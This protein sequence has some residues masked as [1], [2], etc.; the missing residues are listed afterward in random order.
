[1]KIIYKS[2]SIAI[3]TILISACDNSTS[4]NNPD[5]N[6]TQSLNIIEDKNETIDVVENNNEII[7]VIKDK[8]ETSDVIENHNEIINITEDKNETTNSLTNTGINY[9]DAENYKIDKWSILSNYSNSATIENTYDDVLNSRV[10]YLDAKIKNNDMKS[11][12]TFRFNG[13]A[14][15]N[16]KFIQWNMK[17]NQIFTISINVETSKG[18]RSIEYI[19]KDTGAGKYDD[20]IVHGIGSDKTN[21]KWHTIT[22]DLERDVKRYEADNNFI[23]I[24]YMTIQGGGYIDNIKSY[25]VE[26]DLEVNKPVIVSKPGIVLTFDDSLIDNWNEM[27]N[28]FKEKGAVAT[29]FCNRWASHQDWELPADQIALLKSFRD[30]GHEIA[31]HTSDHI[32][33]R[34]H[35]YDN[36]PNK[37]QAYL[38][39]QILEGVADMRNKGFEPTSFSYPYVSG[40]PAHNALIRQELPHIRAF[41]AHVTLTDEPGNQS[42]DDIRTHLE[43][44][45]A[46]K[47]IGVFLS[48]WILYD[49]ANYK[50]KK[51]YKYRISK[52]KLIQIMDMVNE[53]GLEFYTL[54]EAHNIYMNQ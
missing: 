28:T 17:F 24:N 44:L 12:D 40:Q 25:K 39:D 53:L 21:N 35:K 5:T 50:T 26:G 14:N 54:E 9:E 2:L 10:I 8:N 52:E 27:Q 38:E 16:N 3:F 32:S 49:D 51:R 30:N 15:E 43:K 11:Y 45:K 48:H 20:K 46:D 36:E 13:I 19:A 18:T 37:A 23:Q 29:F 22:R 41:F 33:T 7:D 4:T 34:D 6:L 1:M 31:Y 42:L 47:D